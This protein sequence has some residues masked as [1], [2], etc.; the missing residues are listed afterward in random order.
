MQT[1]IP[2]IDKLVDI[3]PGDIVLVGGF[4]KAIESMVSGLV[5]T[6]ENVQW[7]RL[8][9]KKFVPPKPTVE[10]F[11]WNASERNGTKPKPNT[12]VV[13]DG[14]HANSERFNWDPMVGW[15][16]EFAKEN[17]CS[18][19]VIAV[20]EEGTRLDPTT[21][22]PE[23]LVAEFRKQARYEIVFAQ[24]HFTE[25]QCAVRFPN[26]VSAEDQTVNLGSPGDLADQV[27]KR[28]QAS[29]KPAEAEKKS[30]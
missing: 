27:I 24:R 17:K 29:M 10:V 28:V 3:K 23:S 2:Q 13:L 8:T 7:I 21:F 14:I 4:E 11:D 25:V 18:W 1:L 16:V 9:D 12:L 19:V 6:A 20:D 30:G 5:M 26:D 22:L 15:M